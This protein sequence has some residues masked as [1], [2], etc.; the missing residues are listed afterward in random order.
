[1][2]RGDL[3]RAVAGSRRSIASLTIEQGRARYF[4]H[5]NQWIRGGDGARRSRPGDSGAA[6]GDRPYRAQSAGA[7]LILNEVLNDA[8]LEAGGVTY[9][10]TDVPVVEG[11][12]VAERFVV[13]QPRAKGVSCG[14]VK[15]H[16]VCSSPS[17]WCGESR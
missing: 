6:R 2:Q 10:I 7:P 13:P 12:R 1:M 9:D 15:Y 8:R 3:P 17:G 16:E 5:H 11:A 14:S 4:D